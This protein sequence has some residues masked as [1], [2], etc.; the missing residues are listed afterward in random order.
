MP[1]NQQ[2]HT[3]PDE[4]ESRSQRLRRVLIDD[5][6]YAT[7]LLVM[8]VD[9]YGTEGLSWSPETI[10]MQVEADYNVTL[11]QP[12]LDKLLAAITLITTDYFFKDLPKFIDLCNILS[13]DTFDPRVFDPADSFECA[14]GITE[15]MLVS[16]PD[17]EEDPEPFADDIRRYIGEVLRGEGYVQ[18]PDVLRIALDAD[19]AGQVEY[20]FADDPEMFEGIYAVQ[21]DKSGEAV[22][23]IKDNLRE[24][25]SQLKA[26][27]LTSGDTSSLIDKIRQSIKG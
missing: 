16:P 2:S 25:L 19:Y 4:R 6:T 22:E 18:P 26:L 14:W 7:T 10:R 1:E 27:P 12:S 8:F 13:G 15:A 11:P 5:D 21:Q 24:L 3:A 17:F 9:R 23:M 20:D